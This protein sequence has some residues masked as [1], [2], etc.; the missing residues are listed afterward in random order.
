MTSLKDL[1]VHYVAVSR[2]RGQQLKEPSRLDMWCMDGSLDY[3]NNIV[4]F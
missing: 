4:S 3:L 1:S 2:L